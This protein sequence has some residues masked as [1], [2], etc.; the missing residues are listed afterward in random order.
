MG[1]ELKRSILHLLY[2]TRC[3]VCGDFIGAQDCFCAECQEKLKKWEGDFTIPG[4]DS[5]T[6]AYVYDDAVSPAIMLMK[7]GIVGNSD[8]ALASELSKRLKE[9][10]I[11]EHIDLLQPVPMTAEAVL[12]RSCNQSVLICRRLSEMTGIPLT[13]S[14]RKLKTTLPQKTLTRKLREVNLRD[15]F[16]VTDAAGIRGKRILVTDDVCTTGSTLREITR[17]LRENGAKEVHCAS[18]CKTPS[19]E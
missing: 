13:D 1:P 7:D 18:C 16:R 14:V 19:K 9:N 15:A 12:K 2:P 8:Y 10:G 11:T 17:I 5:F 3:P 6:A 4:A